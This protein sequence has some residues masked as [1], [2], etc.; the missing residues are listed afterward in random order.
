MSAPNKSYDPVAVAALP[1]KVERVPAEA[2]AA[3]AAAPT[4]TS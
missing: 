4:S 2:L 1:A 3:I